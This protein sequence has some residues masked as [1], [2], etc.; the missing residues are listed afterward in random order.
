MSFSHSDGSLSSL[1]GS[2][3]GRKSDDSLK[4]KHIYTDKRRQITEREIPPTLSKSIEGKKE[5]NNESYLTA[6]QKELD[7]LKAER[8][9]LMEGFELSICHAGNLHHIYE[10]LVSA[11][12]CHTLERY[13]SL[14]VKIYFNSKHSELSPEEKVLYK[15]PTIS[16]KEL[17]LCSIQESSI[18]GGDTL[19]NN[20]CMKTTK[21]LRVMIIKCSCNRITRGN[22]SACFSEY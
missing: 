9:A 15:V 5:K 11:D 12:L 4:L 18:K 16:P 13:K 22:E 19:I 14:D 20:G 2:S 8:I 6:F 21:E 10:N 1:T 3:A 7:V 17:L